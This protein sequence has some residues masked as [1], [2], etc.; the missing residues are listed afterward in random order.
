MA[1]QVNYL[2]DKGGF[3]ARPDGT[4]A[5]D[6]AKIKDAVRDLTHDLLTLEAEGDYAKAKKMLDTMGVLRPDFQKALG[7]LND[8]PVDIE[9]LFVTADKIAPRTATKNGK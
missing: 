6:Y 1:V 9:P 4:F 5:V 2:I 7:Q 3:V 8:I